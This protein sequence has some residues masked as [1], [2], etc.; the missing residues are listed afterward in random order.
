MCAA[1]LLNRPVD[2]DPSR[3]E[4]DARDFERRWNLRENHHADDGRGC[5]KQGEHQRE[6]G[7]RQSRHGE[8]IANVGDDGGR[9]ADAN[10]RKD[11]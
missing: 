8:L 6:G 10:P 5:G 9:H 3:H 4:Q 2:A 7:A 11:Q 1:A